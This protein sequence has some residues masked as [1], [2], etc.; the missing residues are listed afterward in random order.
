MHT[1]RKLPALQAGI[2]AVLFASAAGQVQAAETFKEVFTQGKAGLAFRYRLEH[3]DQDDFDK[4][5]LASTI[6][7]RE[8]SSSQNFIL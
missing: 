1:K 6:R 5:A 3:V 7:A 4:D 2:L 8:P